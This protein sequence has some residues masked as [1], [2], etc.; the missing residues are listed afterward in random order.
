[1][2]DA[3]KQGVAMPRG[4]AQRAMDQ[5]TK[6]PGSLGR[7]ES[8]AI[9]LAEIQGTLEPTVEKARVLVFAADHG[10]AAE[11][12][13]AYPREVTAQMMANFASGGAAI[14]VLCRSAGIEV[15]VVDVGVDAELLDLPQVVHSKVRRGSRNLLHE[16]AMTAEEMEAAWQVGVEA[17]QRARAAGC[18]AVGLGEMGIGNTTPSAALLSHFTGRSP[19]ETVGRG[20]GVSDDV[21]AH[22]RDVVR[23]ALGRHS[24]PQDARHALAALGG[25]ELASMAGAATAAAQSQI[26]VVVDGFISTVAALAAVRIEPTLRPALFFA[27]RS[28]EA[29]HRIALEALEAEPMLNLDLRLGEATGAALAIPLLQAAARVLREMATFDSAGVSTEVEAP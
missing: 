27:H 4:A 18:D 11:G 1:M 15:E 22:K 7:L 3:A 10:V 13:S 19:E 25:L 8:W 16:P 6:P 12:V 2:K 14:H 24:S 23:R 9:R 5:K 17:V 20:T 21:W 26:P 28:A 29:G